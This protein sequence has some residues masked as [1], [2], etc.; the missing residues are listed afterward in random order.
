MKPSVTVI[1]DTRE[2]TPWEFPDM[3]SQPGT[4]TTGD[5]SIKGLE[6]VISVERKSLSDLLGCIGSDRE[7]FKKELHRLQDYQF[8]ALIIEASYSTLE[9]GRWPHS[10]IHPNAVLGSLAAWQAQYSLPIMLVGNHA[11]GARY[12]ANF[13]YKA[14]RCAS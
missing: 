3:P 2:Q 4:L 11:A 12:C 5:Y 7:R 9:L 13:L 14:A 10:K 8:R 1:I 6:N